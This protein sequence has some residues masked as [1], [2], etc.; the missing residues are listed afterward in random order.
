[1]ALRGS[2]HTFNGKVQRCHV[3]AANQHDLPPR[4]PCTFFRALA[5]QKGA[6]KYSLV[7]RRNKSMLEDR[8]GS[9]GPRPWTN[10]QASWPW[11]EAKDST[12][13]PAPTGEK[14]HFGA[15]RSTNCGP[16]VGAVEW[17]APTVRSHKLASK[18]NRLP[19]FR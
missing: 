9:R 18:H 11:E 13:A 10:P 7:V 16:Q 17:A 12:G 6:K 15:S 4:Q 5:V 8:S 19:T 2:T 3:R 1:M 14:N